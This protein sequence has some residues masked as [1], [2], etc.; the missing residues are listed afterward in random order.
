MALQ[1]NQRFGDGEFISSSRKVITKLNRLEK[2]ALTE[3]SCMQNVVCGVLS[4]STRVVVTHQVRFLPLA[5]L[6]VK[7][8]QGRIVA[9]GTYAELTQKGVNLSELSGSIPGVCMAPHM[10]SVSI[11][12]CSLR[13]RT[14]S[15]AVLGVSC[16][17]ALPLGSHSQQ[18]LRSCCIVSMLQSFLS[19]VKEFLPSVQGSSNVCL[20]AGRLTLP[21]HGLFEA[22]ECPS[23]QWLFR[24]HMAHQASFIIH[25]PIAPA[26]NNRVSRLQH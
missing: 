15:F 16:D 2:Q 9:V 8:E 25:S 11:S 24:T 13:A 18:A 5:D 6:I 12:Y 1:S 26:K 10:S 20:Q 7:M 17:C 4:K 14:C 3:V 21:S 19:N 22:L 23:Q